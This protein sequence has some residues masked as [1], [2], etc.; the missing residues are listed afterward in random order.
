MPR[1]KRKQEKVKTAGRNYSGC[2]IVVFLPLTPFSYLLFLKIRGK[3]E[4]L[5]LL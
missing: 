1:A 4:E 3:G 2:E 5:V